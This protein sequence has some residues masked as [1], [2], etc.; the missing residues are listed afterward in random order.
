MPMPSNLS[1]LDRALLAAPFWTTAAVT[2][3]GGCAAIAVG[4][5]AGYVLSLPTRLLLGV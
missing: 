4:V 5:L 2:F 3:F 1:V